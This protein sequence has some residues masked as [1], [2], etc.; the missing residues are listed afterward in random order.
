MIPSTMLQRAGAFPPFP[1][2]PGIPGAG[3]STYPGHPPPFFP[4]LYSQVRNHYNII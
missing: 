1:G 3:S 4:F 2:Y